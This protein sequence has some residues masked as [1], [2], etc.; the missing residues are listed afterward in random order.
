MPTTKDTKLL[1]PSDTYQK[2]NEV[3]ADEDLADVI[4]ASAHLLL[5]SLLQLMDD[6]Y[7]T[8]PPGSILVNART[9][10]QRLELTLEKLSDEVDMMTS[11]RVD[12]ER[13][14]AL[15]TDKTLN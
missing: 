5:N 13:K 1:P 9:Q 11:D 14:Q 15:E 4:S 3:C 7:V 6:G 2:M 12:D 8:S 10:C